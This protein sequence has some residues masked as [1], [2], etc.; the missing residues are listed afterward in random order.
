MADECRQELIATAFVTPAKR[1]S[2]QQ[3]S[4]EFEYD[5]YTPYQLSR[6][7]HIKVQ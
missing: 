1:M 5:E 6:N 3:G 2:D 4:S 7:K